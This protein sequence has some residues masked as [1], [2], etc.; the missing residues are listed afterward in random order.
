M[1]SNLLGLSGAQVSNLPHVCTQLTPPLHTAWLPM[2]HRRL[3]GPYLSEMLN[4]RLCQE[5]G[6]LPKCSSPNFFC[7]HIELGE[8]PTVLPEPY[9]CGRDRL[10]EK[11]DIE[12]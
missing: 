3:S 9:W 2:A 5:L 7:N 11:G 6:E 10:G 8:R 12:K 4:Y 1:H